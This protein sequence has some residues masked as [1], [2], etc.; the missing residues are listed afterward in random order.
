MFVSLR[1]KEKKAP[2][3]LYIK[4]IRNNVITLITQRNRSSLP[5]AMKQDV[6]QVK[7]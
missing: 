7:N 1:K 3:S 4:S 6:Y 5:I 2:N